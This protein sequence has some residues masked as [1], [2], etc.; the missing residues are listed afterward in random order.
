M[1]SKS[2]QAAGNRGNNSGEQSAGPGAVGAGA[3]DV[4]TTCR[5]QGLDVPD[6]ELTGKPAAENAPDLDGQTALRQGDDGRPYCPTHNC[7]CKATSS[8]KTATYYACP[9]PG[10]TTRA[11]R[12]RPQIKMPA[13]P[14]ACQSRSC[15]QGSGDGDAA[16][17]RFLEVNDKLSTVANLHMECGGCGFHVKVPRPQFAPDLERRRQRD[18]A[19]AAAEDFGER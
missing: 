5:H 3:S 13:E 6:V 10:C 11:K 17:K 12:A 18:L 1:A 15:Q 14:L 7:L 19:A 2:S 4:G 8:H 16:N 9:V